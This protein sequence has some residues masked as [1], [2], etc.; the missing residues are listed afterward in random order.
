MYI[1]ALSGMHILLVDS[2]MCAS[3]R[4]N[5]TAKGNFEPDFVLSMLAQCDLY[6]DPI[7]PS[8]WI[9]IREELP[10]ALLVA[11]SK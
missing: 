6:L 7:D 3:V 8:T 5:P 1:P 9:D 2:L 10:V 4:V 11:G